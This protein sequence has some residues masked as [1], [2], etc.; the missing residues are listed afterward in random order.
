MAD[1]EVT[2]QSLTSTN[3]T[4]NTF[5]Q[6]AESTDFDSPLRYG[7]QNLTGG[8]VVTDTTIV[9]HGNPATVG[10]IAHAIA[11]INAIDVDDERSGGISIGKGVYTIATPL[12]IVDK[13]NLSG[14]GI[15]TTRLD[16]TN[17]AGGI[18]V[19][20]GDLHASTTAYVVGDYVIPSTVSWPN[21]IRYRCTVAGTSGATATFSTNAQANTAVGD[22]FADGTVTW[23][24]VENVEPFVGNFS[25]DIVSTMTGPGIL[26]QRIPGVTVGYLG[27]TGGNSSVEQWALEFDS[28]NRFK[29]EKIDFE[30]ACCG[31]LHNIRDTVVKPFNFGDGVTIGVDMNLTAANCVGIKCL[32]DPSTNDTINNILFDRTEIQGTGDVA[33]AQVAVWFEHAKRNTISHI[34]IERITVGVMEL[35]SDTIRNEFNAIKQMHFLP[36]AGTQTTEGYPYARGIPFQAGA[37]GA[38]FPVRT[39]FLNYAPF[40]AW[41]A[42]ASTQYI[43]DDEGIFGR[44]VIT[45]GAD[46]GGITTITAASSLPAASS[47]DL[48]RHPVMAPNSQLPVNTQIQGGNGTLEGVTQLAGLDFVFGADATNNYRSMIIR[49][50]GAAG[51][52]CALRAIRDTADGLEIDVKNNS[53]GPEISP[54]ASGDNVVIVRMQAGSV[55]TSDPGAVGGGVIVRA[56]GSG[57]NPGSGAGTYV[58]NDADSAW[59]FIG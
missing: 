8:F 56:D 23:R 18:V 38:T 24:A 16:F 14:L 22:T 25:Y 39:N 20:N 29:V 4:A 15:N 42:G 27:A 49:N 3:T 13:I 28:V 19:N 11:Q 45:V 2:F 43:A 51:G 34:D 32:G 58:R 37:T 12:N 57:F 6:G 10:S 30:I 47:A 31:M 59:V 17:N 33:D 21:D 1:S 55:L 5:I 48:T 40:S 46:V 53:D 44:D 52:V 9:D 50:T 54:E 26:L 41:P 36:E 7:I 35:G